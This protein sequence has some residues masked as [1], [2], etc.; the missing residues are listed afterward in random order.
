MAFKKGQHTGDKHPRWKGGIIFYWKKQAL[1]RDD[2]TCRVCG[3]REPKIMDVAHIEP[4]MGWKNRISAGNE[5]NKL[6]NLLTL[7][8]NDHRRFDRGIITLDSGQYKSR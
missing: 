7:C 5:K 2:Y 1:L 6:K 4:I 3:L 8:P